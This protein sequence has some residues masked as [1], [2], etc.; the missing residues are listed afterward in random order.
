M[1]TILSS[2]IEMPEANPT[3]LSLAKEVSSM[4][5]LLAYVAFPIL[6]IALTWA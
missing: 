5:T 1:S 2:Q 4:L 3:A 6:L